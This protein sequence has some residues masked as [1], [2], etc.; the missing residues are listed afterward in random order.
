VRRAARADANQVEIVKAL[1]DMGA[2]VW[3]IKLP[4]DLLICWRGANYLIE[5]KDGK[6]APSARKLTDLQT[7]FFAS[8]R[9]PVFKVESV[10]DA[11]NLLNSL[12]HAA[13]TL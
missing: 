7:D 8:W 9:G 11:V 13:L 12:P 6:K 10:T 5:V 3:N 4:V 1:E 2:G